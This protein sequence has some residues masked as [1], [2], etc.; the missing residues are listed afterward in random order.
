MQRTREVFMNRFNNFL[1]ALVTGLVF[2]MVVFG[3]ADQ[4][5]ITGTVTDAQ[6]GVVTA[7]QIKLTNTDTNFRLETTTDAR[8]V[9][10]FQPIR[11]GHYTLDASAPGFATTTQQ[12]LEVQVNQRLGVDISLRVGAQTEIVNVSANAIPLLQ[13][14]DASTGKVISSQQINDTP[15]AGRNYVWIAQLTAGVA[16][17]TAN[18]PGNA[19]GSFYANGQRSVQ[20]NF[21]LDGVD[22]NSNS[23]DML[24]GAVYVVKPPP[25][26]L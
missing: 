18:S 14:E 25:D 3:Q 23:V 19:T 9:Y 7:A 17:A 12:G 22:N 11:I 2:Q 26:A 10:T 4:G 20:N 24:N 5:A 6:G 8:G 1:L 16:P 13:T 21:I 15:L